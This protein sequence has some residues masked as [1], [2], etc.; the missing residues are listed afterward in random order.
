[1]TIRHFSDM[2]GI[3]SSPILHHDTTLFRSV[4]TW[5]LKVD[6]IKFNFR[7]LS[8][9]SMMGVFFSLFR[10]YIYTPGPGIVMPP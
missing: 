8:S 5:I 4:N 3:E 1:M 9:F 6:M 10:A 7:P 2:H